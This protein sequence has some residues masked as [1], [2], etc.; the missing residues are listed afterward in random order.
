M[1]NK[2]GKSLRKVLCG[3]G[4]YSIIGFLTYLES[5]NNSTVET[6]NVA[7]VIKS[8]NSTID[9]CSN[10]GS[11][12]RVREY[13]T[14]PF[15]DEERSLEADARRAFERRQDINQ[16]SFSNISWVLLCLSMVM[17]AFT[18][19]A[20]RYLYSN[21]PNSHKHANELL[22]SVTRVLMI[23]SLVLIFDFVFFICVADVFLVSSFE[24]LL[25]IM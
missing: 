8:L 9:A 1:M 21:R 20:V 13:L 3:N 25:I 17:L 22:R 5:Q 15:E 12:W 2:T 7:E 10:D 4:Q 6:K 14:E 24:E 11:L 16:Q 19:A 18:F 23:T